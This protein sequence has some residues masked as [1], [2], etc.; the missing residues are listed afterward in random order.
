MGKYCIRVEETEWRWYEVE[1]T[2]SEE[3]EAKC[4][5]EHHGYED[6]AHSKIKDC[7]AYAEGRSAGV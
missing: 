5:E 1:A 7:T 2:S 3:A 6:P 4:L